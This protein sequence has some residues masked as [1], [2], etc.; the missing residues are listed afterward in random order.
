MHRFHLNTVLPKVFLLNWSLLDLA[1]TQRM[2]VVIVYLFHRRWASG[3]FFLPTEKKKYHGYPLLSSLNFCCQ[4]PVCNKGHRPSHALQWMQQIFPVIGRDYRPH[5]SKAVL[6]RR[7]QLPN[8]RPQIATPPPR[9][10][11]NANSPTL[12]TKF[13]PKRKL[14]GRR[15]RNARCWIVPPMAL[16]IILKRPLPQVEGNPARMQ[17]PLQ[18]RCHETLRSTRDALLRKFCRQSGQT[19]SSHSST[20][21]PAYATSLRSEQCGARE[22]YCH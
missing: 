3:E 5:S 7:R 22:I 18:F 4:S 21:S 20:Y 10:R 8:G 2:E 13:P 9:P 16:P 15:S 11:R 1:S 12:P 19:T 6:R 14:L 17:R